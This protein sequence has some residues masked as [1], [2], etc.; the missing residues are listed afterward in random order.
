MKTLI[1]IHHITVDGKQVPV[2]DWEDDA[3]KYRC[4]DCNWSS[5]VCDVYE[6]KT[7]TIDLLA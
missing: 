3:N 6:G 4:D 1:G 7:N 2:P 5:K